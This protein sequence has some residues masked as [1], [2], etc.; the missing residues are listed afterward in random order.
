MEL[1]THTVDNLQK[2]KELYERGVITE[3]ELVAMTELFFER[4]NNDKN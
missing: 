2:Y 1:T 3:E 4:D